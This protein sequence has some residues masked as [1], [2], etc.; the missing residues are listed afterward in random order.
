MWNPSSVPLIFAHRGASIVAPENTIPAFQKALE[1][2]APAIEFDVKLTADGQVVVLHD[3]T[4]DR[5]TNGRGDLRSISLEV[6]QKMDAGI[7]FSE[8]YK[9]TAIPTLTEVLDMFGKK[10]IMNIE[11]TNYSTPWDGLV[12]RVVDV[13]RNYGLEEYILFS[14]FLPRN[15]HLA[16]SLI[17]EIPCGLLTWPGWLGW[18]GRTHGYRQ[19]EYFAIHPNKNDV[20]EKFVNVAHGKG[21]RVHVW[22]V[23]DQEEI[24]HLLNQGVDGIFTDD[25]ALALSIFKKREIVRG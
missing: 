16:A 19:R 13:I 25:P 21:K 3:Q 17:P 9:G 11:L 15:L 5:T 4:V 24:E 10:I 8:S 12:P 6:L 7:R 22:T 2:G 20:S 1:C 14:S 23:N 18:W